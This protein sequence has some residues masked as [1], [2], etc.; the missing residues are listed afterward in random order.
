MRGPVIERESSECDEARNLYNGAIYGSNYDRLVS[1]KGKYDPTNF[2][3]VNQNIRP[4]QR[5]RS[6]IPVEIADRGIE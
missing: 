5:P 2:L 1:L 3:H 6:K 4:G